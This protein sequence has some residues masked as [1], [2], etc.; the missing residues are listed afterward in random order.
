MISEFFEGKRVSVILVYK[1]FTGWCGYSSVGLHVG[2][3][4]TAEYLRAHGVQAKPV[5]VRHNVDLYHYLRQHFVSHCVIMAPW[6]TPLDL[7]SLVEHFNR[8]RFVVKSHSNVAG[9]YGDYRGIGNLRNYADQTND[10]PNLQVAGNAAPFAK[11]FTAAYEYDM[12]TLPDLYPIDAVSAKVR[13]RGMTVKIGAFGALRPEKNLTTAAAAA[14]LIAK[15]LRRQVQFHLNSGGERDGK[16]LM[17]T[18]DQMC[19]GIP[20]FD[21]IKHKWMDWE[22]FFALVGRMDLLLQP[23][24]TES[25]NIVTADGIAAQVPS[26]VSSAIR[27]APKSWMAESDDANDVARVGLRLLGNPHSWAEGRDALEF[28]NRHG[29]HLWRKYL[30]ESPSSS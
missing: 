26:V 15:P 25:F 8:I 29:F 9:L 24:F 30:R 7:G 12:L 1:D 2:A 4:K 3:V 10:Y 21:V 11:W 17:T 19:Q 28:H 18:I 23:S 6:I 14:L 5:P 27:W 13:E 16:G 22:K 20:G